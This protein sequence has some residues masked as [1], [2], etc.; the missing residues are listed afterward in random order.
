MRNW[1]TFERIA[2]DRLLCKGRIAMCWL[3][4][5]AQ[6]WWYPTF[7]LIPLM[8][9]A[10]VECFAG[11]H[12]W[13]FLIAVN[14][15]M[16]GCV[17]AAMLGALTGSPS[18]ILFGGLVG[19]VAGGLLFVSYVPLGS[20]VFAFASATSLIVLLTHVVGVPPPWTVPLAVAAGLAG[21]LG[22]LAVS[23]P[24]MIVIASVAG[25]Q[26]IASAWCAYHMPYDVVP[27]PNVVDSSESA[28]FIALAAAGLLV[29]FMTSRALRLGRPHVPRTSPE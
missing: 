28:A 11:Y 24:C 12:A 8:A 27:I 3:Q 20:V 7:L 5:S 23:R 4:Q 1:R 25:A 19:A 2:V 14:G 29:Q 6:L 13:R 22:A 15:A 9:L 17:A 10:C 18:M 16:L 21:A 26:Q